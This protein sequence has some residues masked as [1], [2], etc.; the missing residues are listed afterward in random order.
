MQNLNYSLEQK[1]FIERYNS[2]VGYF[3]W[4]TM[5]KR[6]VKYIIANNGHHKSSP[7]FFERLYK[8]PAY[9]LTDD[10]FESLFRTDIKPKTF[11]QY[12]PHL[13]AHDFFLFQSL[14]FNRVCYTYVNMDTMD[15]KKNHDVSGFFHLRFPGFQEDYS[16][17]FNWDELPQ[18]DVDQIGNSKDSCCKKCTNRIY[19][20]Q[21]N[22][23]ANFILLLNTQ[24]EIVSEEKIGRPTRGKG[25]KVNSPNEIRS[26]NWVGKTFN[27]KISKKTIPSEVA[28][29]S[30]PKTSHWRRGHWHTVLQGPGRQQ[31]RMKWFQPTFIVGNA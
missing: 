11:L 1:N 20:M 31:K 16:F 25:F 15:T 27:R 3:S 29:S 28:G 30:S 24:P 26:V 2:P 21:L 9:F 19:N 23:V 4:E 6:H 7:R 22:L 5:A 14:D 12:R 10:L 18:V 8:A 17:A 13:V